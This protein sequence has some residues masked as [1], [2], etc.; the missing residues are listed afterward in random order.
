MGPHPCYGAPSTRTQ[1]PSDAPP[2]S[3]L[4][5]G[6]S[7]FRQSQ[8]CDAPG[9][10]RNSTPGPRPGATTVSRTDRSRTN[11]SRAVPSTP[12]RAVR[13]CAPVEPRIVAIENG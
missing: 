10:P 9:S 6:P 8:T 1:I 11:S 4:A 13:V 7:S 2:A 3:A 5:D 12:V